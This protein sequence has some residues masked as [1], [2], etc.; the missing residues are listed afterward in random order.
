MPKSLGALGRQ[1][2]CSAARTS[3]TGTRPL[4]TLL[5]APAAPPYRSAAHA[6]PTHPAHPP[7]AGGSK[8]PQ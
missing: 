2:T 5:G 8:R 6:T 3:T 7:H 1:P 4:G